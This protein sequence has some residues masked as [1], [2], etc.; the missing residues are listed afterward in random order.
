MQCIAVYIIFSVVQSSIVLYNEDQKERET[1][2]FADNT[3]TKTCKKMQAEIEKRRQI[4]I[5]GDK[6]TSRQTGRARVRL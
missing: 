4:A 3:N 2:G 6:H 5:L 1:K